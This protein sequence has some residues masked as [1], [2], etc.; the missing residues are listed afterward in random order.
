LNFFLFDTINT[1]LA[2]ILSP[3]SA[4]I[5]SCEAAKKIGQA[6]NKLINIML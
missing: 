2:E 6:S 3:A 5:L 4:A 1:F